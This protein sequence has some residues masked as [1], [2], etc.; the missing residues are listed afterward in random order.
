MLLYSV[1]KKIRTLCVC[2]PVTSI[3]CLHYF[4]I[5]HDCNAR[6]N[7][8]KSCDYLH[9]TSINNDCPKKLTGLD[10]ERNLP[11][12]VFHTPILGQTVQPINQLYGSCLGPVM[13]GHNQNLFNH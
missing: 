10:F 1:Q 8:N 12:P 13:N 7:Q 4:K 6:N 9:A 3:L 5:F 2:K 11:Y